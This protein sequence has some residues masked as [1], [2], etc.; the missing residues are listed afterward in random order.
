MEHKMIRDLD[1]ASELSNLYNKIQFT[2]CWF[3]FAKSNTKRISILD[4]ESSRGFFLYLSRIKN[5]TSNTDF[6]D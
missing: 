3:Q 6:K 4:Y 1:F 5:N 2:V